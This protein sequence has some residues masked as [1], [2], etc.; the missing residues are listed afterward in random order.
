V[1]T[2][3]ST[4]SYIAFFDVDQ[5]LIHTNSGTYLVRMAFAKGLMGKKDIIHALYL[6]LLHK[7]DFRN[8]ERI[9]N[10]M[11]GWV[12]GHAEEDIIQ[13]S[14]EVFRT[15]LID[16]LFPEIHREILFHKNRNAKTVILSS[17][18]RYVCALLASHLGMDDVICSEL[19]VHEGVLTGLPAGRLCYGDEKAIRLKD[20]C[21]R[22]NCSP[23]DAYYYAD[24]ISD[25]QALEAVGHPVCINPDRKLAGIARSRQWTIHQWH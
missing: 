15:F 17:A 3:P 6:S 20:Y 5:T 25:L 13:L 22:M 10:S 23:G 14:E 1:T 19:E 24:S 2:V 8:A 9:I 4:Y 12:K 21:A 7:F 11:A 16:A 18:I